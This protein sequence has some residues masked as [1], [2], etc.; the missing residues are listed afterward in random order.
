VLRPL[1][2][3]FGSILAAMLLG[4]PLASPTLIAVKYAPPWAVA[5][6]GSLAG[7]LASTFDYHFFRRTSKIAI[8]KRALDHPLV[9]TVRRWID[10][11]PALTTFAFASFPLPFL[12]AR[13]LVPLSGIA[14]WR[15]VAAVALGRFARIFV[16]GTVGELLE[17]PTPV[18]V[19]LLVGGVMLSLCAELARRR[20]WIGKK[21]APQEEPPPPAEPP[22]PDQG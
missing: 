8:L 14:L 22:P 19:G 4:L 21:E 20:G 12:I 1:G 15:Y 17:I 6:A 13:V 16:I 10:V 9:G 3:Y 2:V 7:A 11:A 18:L 5:I